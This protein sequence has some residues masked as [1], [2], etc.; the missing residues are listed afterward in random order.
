M[1]KIITA[2]I[3]LIGSYH[4]LVAGGFELRKR[5]VTG[6]ALSGSLT[7]YTQNASASAYNP[8]VTGFLPEKAMISF[9]GTGIFS[10]TSYFETGE[11][12]SQSNHPMMFFPSLSVTYQFS[13]MISAGLSYFSAYGYQTRWEDTWPGR[14]V[15][16]ES[17]LRSQTLQPSVGISFAE[18]FALGA[19]V[20]IQ[21][22]KIKNRKAL[23]TGTNE[24]E[25]L[26]EGKGSGIGFLLGSYFEY[27]NSF[28]AALTIQWSGNMKFGGTSLTYINI[29]VSLE[30]LYPLPGNF[31]V[32]YK[33]PYILTAG[34]KINFTEELMVNAEVSY[35][36]W[37]RMDSIYYSTEVTNAGPEYLH[38]NNSLSARLGVQFAFS[39]ELKVKGG[40]AYDISPYGADFLIPSNPDA[41]NVGLS[42]GAEFKPGARLSIEVA[43]GLEN[44]FERKGMDATNYLYGNYNTTRYFLAAGINYHF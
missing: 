10:K 26:S 5:N 3:L 24:A 37:K 12:N 8:A 2:T 7:T 11:E 34:G 1:K 29:P 39:E 40:V 23:P 16:V 31:D 43:T 9:G 35:S 30:E 38:L 22:G 27:E 13:D 6:F 41:N 25:A 44:Y 28:A 21:N 18:S 33:L 32:T 15:S 17:S 19:A 14:F 20:M 36:G 42:L 4:F